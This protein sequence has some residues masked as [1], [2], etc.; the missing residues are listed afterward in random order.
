M[1]NK[2][3]KIEDSN[4]NN[5]IE[6]DEVKINGIDLGSVI[7]MGFSAISAI[8]L[9]L[10]V[11]GIEIGEVNLEGLNYGVVNTVMA[12]LMIYNTWKNNSFTKE[13]KMADQIMHSLKDEN[14]NE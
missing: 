4:G 13:A 2:I 5:E 1:S 3:I 9:M 7:R 6:I 8:L 14:T 10:P 12:I 11:F